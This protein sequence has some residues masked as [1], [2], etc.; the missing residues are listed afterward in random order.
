[1]TRSFAVAAL[2]LALV[3]LTATALSQQ[4]VPIDPGALTP[5]V[6]HQV[7]MRVGDSIVV[8]GQPIGCQV[9]QRG[10]HAVIECG[11]TGDHIAGTY[12]TI[13]GA[14]TVK[15]ARLRSA[16]AARTIL[17]ATHGGAWRAC[18]M[19]ARASRSGGQWCH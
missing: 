18:G 17:T 11:R 16:T 19:R 9:V 3:G 7:T 12:M 5:G 4:P 15:V 8:D 10:K 1:M 13:V 2:L 6:P 14:R